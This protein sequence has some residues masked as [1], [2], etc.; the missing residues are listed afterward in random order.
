[1]SQAERV[2]GSAAAVA[3]VPSLAEVVARPD[4][5]E[6]LPLDVCESL[7]IEAAA[8]LN[9]KIGNFAPIT[10]FSTASFIDATNDGEGGNDVL[11]RLKT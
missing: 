3:G 6:H 4:L 10:D 9:L 2:D 7:A 8:L 11:V 5:L 1:M